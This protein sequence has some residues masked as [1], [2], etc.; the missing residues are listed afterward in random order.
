MKE[1]MKESVNY[2]ESTGEPSLP[3]AY[4]WSYIVILVPS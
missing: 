1:K 4:M 3:D 2:E